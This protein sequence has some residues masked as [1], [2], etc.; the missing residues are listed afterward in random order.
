MVQLITRCSQLAAALA[1]G[2][3]AGDC[4]AFEDFDPRTGIPTE[5]MAHALPKN[6]D[7]SGIRKWLAERRAGLSAVDARRATED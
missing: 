7:P 4:W 1:I 6:G 5:S 2:L 3:F